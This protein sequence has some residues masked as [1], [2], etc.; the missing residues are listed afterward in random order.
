MMGDGCWEPDVHHLP[1]VE[2]ALVILLLLLRRRGLGLGRV[3]H[4]DGQVSGPSSSS[5][6][7]VK[8]YGLLAR[9]RH[10]V[11][12]GGRGRRAVVGP[13]RRRMS[14]LEIQA[15]RESVESAGA[16]RRVGETYC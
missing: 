1:T 11:A 6:G 10:S 3:V 15:R 9:R 14:V 4:L 7:R 16:G 13:V 12:L 2:A 5:G 8:S